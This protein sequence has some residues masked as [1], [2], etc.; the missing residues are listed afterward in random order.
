M[1]RAVGKLTSSAERIIGTGQADAV[2]IARELLRDPLLAIA[3]NP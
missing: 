1:T 3:S 2:I